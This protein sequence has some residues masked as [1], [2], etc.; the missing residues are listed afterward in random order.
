MLRETGVRVL[1]VIVAL[2]LTCSGVVAWKLGELS[3]GT[4]PA[5]YARFQEAVAGV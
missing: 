1:L 2:M 4:D 3:N 5:R